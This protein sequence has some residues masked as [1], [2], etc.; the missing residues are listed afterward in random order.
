MP[1]TLYPPRVRPIED[2]FLFF[3]R[4][5]WRLLEDWAFPLEVPELR[6]E[7]PDPFVI[8][9]GYE[10]DRASTPR[11][12]WLLGF[13]RDG[14]VEVRA[15]EHDYLCDLWLGGSEWLRL[16]LGGRLPPCPPAWAIHQHF[17]NGLL[18]EGMRPLKA[19]IM[20]LA[21]KLFGPGGRLR[22]LQRHRH[23]HTRR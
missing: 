5:K 19:R 1:P 6:A 9:K 21:V 7:F 2:P 10:F 12:A 8:P 18:Q 16:R 4:G 15:L 14:L 23:R 3:G 13:T 11:F 20:G 22:F 17:E